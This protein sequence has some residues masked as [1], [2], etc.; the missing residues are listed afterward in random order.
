MP[1]VLVSGCSLSDYC[2]W[3]D[4][5]NKSDPR[6]WYN[7][8]SKE[9]N[10]DTT[11]VSYGGKSNREI[12]HSASQALFCTNTKFDLVIIQLT[13]TGRSWFFNSDDWHDFN[14]VNANSITNYQT[15]EE[16]NALNLFRVR[17]FNRLREVERDLVHL[18]HLHKLAELTDTK[19][20]LLNFI[21]FA[22][23]CREMHDDA[24][25][26]AI[27]GDMSESTVSKINTL[28]KS[29]SYSHKLGFD[30]PLIDQQLDYADNNSHPGKKSNRL[31]ADLI[32]DV[33]KQI[34]I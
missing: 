12:L 3:G 20:I 28:Y 27:F 22:N 6:C 32:N 26:D 17:F 30:R 16:Y 10:F 29:L 13:S 9:N 2:G 7:I 1:K 19:L 33:I 21:D 25:P 18:V 5:G 31:Y 24:I 4:P 23:A 15:D 8:V 14:I 34:G 11:N